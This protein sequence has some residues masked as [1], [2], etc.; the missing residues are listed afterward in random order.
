[1]TDRLSK[2]RP[3][4]N[5]WDAGGHCNAMVVDDDGYGDVCGYRAPTVER[6]PAVPRIFGGI[7][8]YEAEV[9]EPDGPRIVAW[10]LAD[11]ADRADA[12]FK[13]WL[14]KHDAHV[15]AQALREAASYGPVHFAATHRDQ[16]S[17]GRLLVTQGWLC[18]RAD[19]IEREAGR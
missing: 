9:A 13:K 8:P 19:R 3:E 18:D 6:P 17:R 16:W 14:A 2:H 5:S 7:L 10:V 15:A 11:Y 4:H 1:M 12:I